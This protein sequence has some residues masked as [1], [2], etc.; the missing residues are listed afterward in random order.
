MHK[1]WTIYDW[2][3]VEATNIFILIL[4]WLSFSIQL[5]VSKMSKFIPK[6]F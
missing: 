2:Q 5:N 3:L 4:M 6:S 1:K